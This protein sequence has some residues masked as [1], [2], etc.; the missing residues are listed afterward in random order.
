ML[1]FFMVAQECSPAAD[2]KLLHS[3][4]QV[5]SSL[6][7]YAIGVVGGQLK[8][9]PKNLAEAIATAKE[10]YKQGL[11][12]SLGLAQVNRYNLEKYDLTLETAFDPCANL[13]AGASIFAEC[14]SRAEKSSPYQAKERALSCYYSGNFSR[15]FKIEP[16]GT[17]YV[18]RVVNSSNQ[19]IFI[20]PPLASDKTSAIGFI[21]HQSTYIA[22]HSP[23]V[24][25][26]QLDRSPVLITNHQDKDRSVIVF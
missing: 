26:R 3:I 9:Q 21:P 7:P 1:D 6:N 18:Q 8:R 15:G 2:A 25:D 16:S 12:F 5:E 11:N 24:F 13:K 10:L 20:A 23:I 14:L 19:N 17:S 4:V 22:H